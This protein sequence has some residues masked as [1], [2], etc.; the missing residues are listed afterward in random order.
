MKYNRTENNKLFQPITNRQKINNRTLIYHKNGNDKMKTIEDYR[1]VLAAHKGDLARRYPIKSLAIFGSTAR[2]DITPES[3]VDILVEFT[4]PL[5]LRFVDLAE[6]LE[7]LLGTQ[8]DLV[9][10]GA[11]KERHWNYISKDLVYV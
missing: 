4:E 3:D 5:G 2:G 1:A 10:R 11:V 7:E 8:V 6:E 9:S